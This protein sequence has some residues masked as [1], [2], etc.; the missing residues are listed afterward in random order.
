MYKVE[1]VVLVYLLSGCQ[2]QENKNSRISDLTTLKNDFLQQI[3][4]S[5]IDEGPF[6][7][8]YNFRTVFLSQEIISLFGELSVLDRMPHGWK[9][10]DGKTLCKINKKWQEIGLKDLF[11]TAEKRERVRTVCEQKLKSDPLSYFSGNTPLRKTLKNEELHDF[12]LDDRYLI[13]IFEPY[14]VAGVTDGP[15]TINIPFTSF[16]Q[17]SERAHPVFDMISRA[18]KSDAYIASW[19]EHQS[20]L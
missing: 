9:R 16:K 20:T 17:T 6:S 13:L 15:Y 10:Y 4:T 14:C 3:T 11:N 2:Q 1:I 19:N 7:F 12:V 18:V 8:N 5:I